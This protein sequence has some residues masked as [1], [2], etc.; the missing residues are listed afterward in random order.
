MGVEKVFVVEVSFGTK[1]F[2]DLRHFVQATL[3]PLFQGVP[4]EDTTIVG[5]PQMLQN[6]NSSIVPTF[7]A[8][9]IVAPSFQHTPVGVLKLTI[10]TQW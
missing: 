8:M 9:P 6:V 3:K 7:D 4:I 10:L 5:L 1:G 2:K